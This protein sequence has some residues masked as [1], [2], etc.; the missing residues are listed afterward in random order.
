MAIFPNMPRQIR[1][2][3]LDILWAVVPLL[4]LI[5][6]VRPLVIVDQDRGVAHLGVLAP[7]GLRMRWSGETLAFACP[8]PTKPVP[9]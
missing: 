1:V 6:V 2:E 5:V 9:V 3:L 4:E 7:E 8:I